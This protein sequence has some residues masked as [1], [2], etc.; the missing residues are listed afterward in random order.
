MPDKRC[1]KSFQSEN[2]KLVGETN[3]STQISKTNLK[4]EAKINNRNKTLEIIACRA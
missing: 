1:N 3:S 2:E 4:C